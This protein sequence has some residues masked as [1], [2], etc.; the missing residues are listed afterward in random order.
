MVQPY[1]P[2]EHADS[3]NGQS[4]ASFQHA[5]Q[6][7][8]TFFPDMAGWSNDIPL[9]PSYEGSRNANLFDQHPELGVCLADVE[10]GPHD[11][12]DFWR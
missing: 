9:Y 1:S 2:W 10:S 5:G 12:K 7:E 8:D 4:N 6:I 3:L 11:L